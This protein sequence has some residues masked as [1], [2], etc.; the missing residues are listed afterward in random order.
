M[1]MQGNIVAKLPTVFGKVNRF[2]KLSGSLS[3]I[4]ITIGQG[5]PYEGEYNI[6]PKF[7]PQR[8]ETKD[9][10]LSYDLTVEAIAV[11]KTSNESGGNT[12]IIGG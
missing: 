1:K 5:K 6:I 2:S 11:I 10:T 9:R 4:T 8:L 7:E 12:V 3:G